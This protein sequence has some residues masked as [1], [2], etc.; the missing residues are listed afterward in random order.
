MPSIRLNNVNGKLIEWARDDSGYS[1]AEVANTCGINEDVLEQ[2][3][4]NKIKPTLVQAENLA[5]KFSRPVALFYLRDIPK[6]AKR[7]R[8]DNR[9]PQVATDF[10]PVTLLA[11]R[12]LNLLQDKMIELSKIFTIQS[13]VL[14]SVHLNS[15]PKQTADILRKFLGIQDMPR[16]LHRDTALDLLI[17]KIEEKGIAVSQQSIPRSELQGASSF[18]PFP[19]ILVNQTDYK[20]SKIFTLMHELCHLALR[21]G[22]YCV[23]ETNPSKDIERFCNAVAG[24]M[25]V[26]IRE[27]ESKIAD[28][29][30][31]SD[32]MLQ[33]LSDYFSVSRQVILLRLI[34]NNYVGDELWDQKNAQWRKEYINSLGDNVRRAGPVTHAIRE[35]GTKLTSLIF[36]GVEN[37]Q[38]SLSQAS[39]YLNVR[40]GILE[41]IHRRV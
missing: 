32:E 20:S 9:S 38:I 35:N 39:R 17:S 30:P 26:P 25:L 6:T 19:V 2:I 31:A 22:G 23:F 28:N 8:P 1:L 41:D 33:K 14:P 40:S 16:V 11:I 24:E 29:Y 10:S 4:S 15:D 12:K 37:G 34:H 27:L 18:E 3:E 5:K 36:K 13:P 7:E 21:S